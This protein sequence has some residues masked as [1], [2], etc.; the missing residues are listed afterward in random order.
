MRHNT[1]PDD[2]DA[3]I[4]GG[5]PAGLS[6]A[7]LLGRACR[8]VVIFDHGKPRNFAA[9]AVHGFLG[10]DGIKPSELRERGRNQALAYG[11]EFVDCAVTSAT[12]AQ[13]ASGHPTIFEVR[14]NSRLVKAR[15]LLLATGVAD[16]LPDIPGVREL[17]GRR[18][19]H[20]PYCDGWE[21]RQKHVVALGDA[22]PVAKLALTLR[23]WSDQVTAC[24][25]GERMSSSDRAQLAR[26]E[27]A[28]REDKIDF[29]QE[30]EP[31]GVE[32][33]FRPGERLTCDA[34]FFS[35]DQG[36]RSPLAEK[37]GCEI[38]KDG[39]V[40]TDGKQKTCVDGVFI[41][42]DAAGDVQ[43]AIVAAAQGAIAATAINRMLMAQDA[44]DPVSQSD[45]PV[46]EKSL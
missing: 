45:Q 4:I 5:G 24:T 12:R 44:L 42:G 19:H 17:Y 20:C 38:D 22:K 36:Q 41:A 25:N 8:R 23:V 32:I 7:L 26:H 46:H 11:V 15:A 37:L 10:L 28:W 6:A 2:Y 29:L 16:A 21:H 43:F 39:L 27:V 14:A 3:A 33:A 35:A 34:V 18:V 1:S 30:A 31:L 13:S 9:Q 40:E